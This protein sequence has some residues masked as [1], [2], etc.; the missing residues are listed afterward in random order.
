MLNEKIV[1][2]EEAWLGELLEPLVGLTIKSVGVNVI[3]DFGFDRNWPYFVVV[4]KDK[5]GQKVEAQIEFWADPEGNGPGYMA[6][7]EELNDYLSGKDE[8]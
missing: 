1:K 7:L 6:G 2:N 4:A 8:A 3:D 5:N